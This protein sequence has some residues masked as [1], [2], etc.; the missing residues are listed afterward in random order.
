MTRLQIPFE[1]TFKSPFFLQNFWVKKELCFNQW[2]ISCIHNPTPPARRPSLPILQRHVDADVYRLR[3]SG[4]VQDLRHEGPGH[5]GGVP[6]GPAGLGQSAVP[7]A[8]DPTAALFV[9]GKIMTDTR[10]L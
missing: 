6:G 2:V 5:A 10:S 3:P 1:I 8:G 4:G 7:P 9:E